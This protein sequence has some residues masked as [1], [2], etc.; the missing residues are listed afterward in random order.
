MRHALTRTVSF[1][2]EHHYGLPG[3]TAAENQARFGALTG[4]H[5]HDYTCAVTVE[6]RLDAATGMLLDLPALDRVLAE[7][8]GRLDGGNLNR[9]IPPFAAGQQ[10]TCEALA[11]WLFGRIAPRLPA[12]ARLGRVRVAED[13]TLHAEC[14]SDR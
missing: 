10:P 11:A 1:R 7:E 6:G 12:G 9:D 13:A 8:I 2:A 14:R 5:P 3:L 4:P